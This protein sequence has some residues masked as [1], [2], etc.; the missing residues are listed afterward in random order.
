[1]FR[2]LLETLER[3]GPVVYMFIVDVSLFPIVRFV[4]PKIKSKSVQLYM[5]LIFGLLFNIYLF[6]WGMVYFL[7][8]VVFVYP[9]FGRNPTLPIIIAFSLNCLNAAYEK[10]YGNSAWAF[11]LSCIFMIFVNRVF[12]FSW[13]VYY[14]KLK[15]EK[16][17]IKRKYNSDFA[18]EKVP[19][20]VEWI[21]YCVTPFGSNSGPHIEYKLF[22]YMLDIGNREPVKAD[23]EDRKNALNKW[24]SSFFFAITTPITLKFCTVDF[25]DTDFFLGQPFFV[26]LLLQIF[27]TVG[28]TFRYFCAWLPV[29]AAYCE[30]GLGSLEISSF[31]DI[32]NSSLIHV[33]SSPTINDFFVRWNHSVHLTFKRY[34][35]YPMMD[36]YNVPYMI[37]RNLVFIVSAVWHGFDPVYYLVMFETLL[38]M[39][40]DLNLN[41]LYPVTSKSFSK[42][43]LRRIWVLGCCLNNFSTWIFRDFHSF[44]LVRKRIGF[45]WNIIII[46]VFLFTTFRVRSLNSNNSNIKKEK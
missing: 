4:L 21:A 9:F 38:E 41:K 11:D 20:L 17:E 31:E 32:S 19:N 15:R 12:S 33:L 28:L 34:L 6:R 46:I 43:W 24:Y 5:H 39:N 42:M 14:G 25:Y 22:D 1:M 40:A 45:F 7:L 18:L 2:A 16:K 37:A 35:Y 10:F 30:F 27:V 29:E 13:N 44:I 23:S 26:K 8:T 36:M 3:V